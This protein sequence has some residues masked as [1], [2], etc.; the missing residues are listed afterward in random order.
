MESFCIWW[1]CR[2]WWW[3]C[4]YINDVRIALI[5]KTRLKTFISVKCDVL[6]H[7][8]IQFGSNFLPTTQLS[9]LHSVFVSV[10]LLGFFEI[11]NY[12]SHPIKKFYKYHK[13]ES[14]AFKWFA[15]WISERACEHVG[16]WLTSTWLCHYE[17]AITFCVT[18]ECA[19]IIIIITTFICKMKIILYNS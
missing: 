6:N 10:F 7:H 11:T 19:N 16:G 1:V 15:L 3:P 17:I 8:S 13:P 2:Q 4:H 12:L 5:A 9:K 18:N 14:M